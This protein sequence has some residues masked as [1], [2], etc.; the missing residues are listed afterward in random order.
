MSEIYRF[1]R[2][3]SYAFV[4]SISFYT[5]AALV[6]PTPPKIPQSEF[7]VNQNIPVTVVMPND[8]AA[9]EVQLR[10]RFGNGELSPL[11]IRIPH[12][13]SKT[14]TVTH[15]VAGQYVLFTRTCNTVEC[16]AYSAGTA[17]TVKPSY[18]VTS[19]AGSGGSIIPASQSVAAGSQAL[20]RLTPATYYQIAQVQ[21]CGG[22][23]AG[24]NYT[25]AAV[26]TNCAVTAS[27]TPAPLVVPAPPQPAVTTVTADQNFNV[28]VQRTN[29][30]NAVEI[31]IRSLEP[32][33]NVKVLAY[34][35]NNFTG[36][37][38]VSL[39]LSKVGL[40][41][42]HTST[43]NTVRCSELSSFVP[44]TVS[45]TATYTVSTTATA[46]GSINPA[47]ATVPQGQTASFSIIPLQGYSV[48]SVT[49]CNGNFFNGVF[50][51]AAIYA[52]C[53]VAASFTTTGTTQ[54]TIYLHSDVLGSVIAESDS[55]GNLKNSTEYK[56]FGES[57]QN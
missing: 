54:Q 56:P 3:A 24:F 23:L 1:I 33:G 10:T 2:Q 27:F 11:F 28:T 39:R 45:N 53:N 12:G 4:F 52:N 35:P 38:T 31:Q 48:S 32:D 50:T 13:T 21:G 49:G 16:S 42:L 30:A 17:F 25:T 47:S 6:V 26:T 46:G 40:N 36:N 19:T 34:I 20:L 14:V 29:D 37:K 41:K 57:K 43:C 51:T 44:I 8:P 15:N 55:N 5:N 7:I 18:T 22:S 9:I